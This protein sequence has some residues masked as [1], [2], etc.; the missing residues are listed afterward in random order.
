MRA[1]DLSGFE[2]G[3]GGDIGSGGDDRNWEVGKARRRLAGCSSRPCLH[4][5]LW[6]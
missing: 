5:D 6:E 4:I 1:T 3:T 2:A